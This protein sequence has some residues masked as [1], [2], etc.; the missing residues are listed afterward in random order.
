[1]TKNIN[2]IRSTTL[3]KSLSG[4]DILTNLKSGKFKV[5]AYNLRVL[6]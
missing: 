2:L 5:T 6:Q 1:M 4:E 3:I